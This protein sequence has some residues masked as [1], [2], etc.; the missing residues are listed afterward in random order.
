MTRRPRAGGREQAVRIFREHERQR[1]LCLGFA[2]MALRIAL[3][4]TRS[5]SQVPGWSARTISPNSHGG[6]HHFTGESMEAHKCRDAPS[7]SSG[8]KQ[9]GWDSRPG[10]PPV[11]GHQEGLPPSFFDAC[12]LS[13]SSC[14]SEM[15]SSSASRS[16]V[17]CPQCLSTPSP[18]APHPSSQNL[19]HP[20]MSTLAPP[21]GLCGPWS[22]CLGH[23][24][25]VPCSLPYFRELSPSRLF[26][27]R[28]LP[29]PH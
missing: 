6:P 23:T 10:P 4:G 28:L 25:H 11:T 20:N 17:N 26:S 22:P 3:V 13:P 27:G 12:S 14:Q 8:H 18:S 1:T 24:P 5:A 21:R 16:Y 29:P 15:M 7:A 2:L 19:T 9:Q